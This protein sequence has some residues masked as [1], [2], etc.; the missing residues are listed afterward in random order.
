MEMNSDDPL[1][2]TLTSGGLALLAMIGVTIVGFVVDDLVHSLDKSGIFVY[3]LFG[4]MAAAAC[5]VI[6]RKNPESVWYVPPI[7]NLYLIFSAIVEDNFWKSP[8]GSPGI[9]MW[10]PICSGWVLCLVVSIIAAVEGVKR[11]HMTKLPPADL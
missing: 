6:V 7:V 10:I 4:V 8:A 9:P 1:L 5:F 2:A 11:T 3:V